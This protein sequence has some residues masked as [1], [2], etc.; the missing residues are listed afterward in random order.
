MYFYLS[1]L[2]SQKVYFLVRSYFSAGREWGFEKH[3]LL[4][5]KFAVEQGLNLEKKN[6]RDWIVS[7][8]KP[9]LET[10]QVN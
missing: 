4:Q 7:E 1:L 3:L 8:S 9:L 10:L 2:S 5:A 6:I